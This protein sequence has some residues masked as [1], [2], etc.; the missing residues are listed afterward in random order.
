[1]QHVWVCRTAPVHIMRHSKKYTKFCC[2]LTWQHSCPFCPACSVFSKLTP[3]AAEFFSG[4]DRTVLCTHLPLPSQGKKALSLP[5]SHCFL[6]TKFCES[7]A[8]PTSAELEVGGNETGHR[9]R[10]PHPL[11]QL[12][13]LLHKDDV[14]F[15][16]RAFP[17]DWQVLL[18]DRNITSLGT[19][20]ESPLSDSERTQT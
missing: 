11:G 16:Y 18:W 13:C 2:N 1:M 4:L 19:G 7:S 10:F 14:G 5:L 12:S 9:R 6:K 8:C 20:F 15:S 17:T 3:A